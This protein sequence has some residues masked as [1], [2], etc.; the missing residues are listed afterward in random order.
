MFSPQ[1]LTSM[2][3]KWCSQIMDWWW[4]D[5]YTSVFP[6]NLMQNQPRCIGFWSGLRNLWLFPR[7]V[8]VQPNTEVKESLPFSIFMPG[9]QSHPNWM[10]D[11]L[12]LLTTSGCFPHPPPISASLSFLSSCIVARGGSISGTRAE[13]EALA[14]QLFSVS[15]LHQ[16]VYFIP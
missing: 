1:G 13:V 5:D 7:C 14:L 12:P 2:A 10:L 6:V 8:S 15:H 3:W 9:P 11:N 4:C 16:S